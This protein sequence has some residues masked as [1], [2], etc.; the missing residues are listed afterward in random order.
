MTNASA[1][2]VSKRKCSEPKTDDAGVILTA[3]KKR[4]IKNE[5][6]TKEKGKNMKERWLQKG[7]M[8]TKTI[9]ES[10]KTL[11]INKFKTQNKINR[12]YKNLK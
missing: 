2:F 11:K 4:K 5:R 3:G 10:A 9:Q 12:I 1:R 8:L 7:L 6:Q